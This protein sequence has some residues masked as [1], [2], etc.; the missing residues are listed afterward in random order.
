M[1]LWGQTKCTVIQSAIH[2]PCLRLH[3]ICNK[4]RNG[5]CGT[6]SGGMAEGRGKKAT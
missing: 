3:I 6:G 2:F 1:R 5:S 4:H